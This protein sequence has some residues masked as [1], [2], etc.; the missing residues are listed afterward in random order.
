MFFKLFT[1]PL[2]FFCTIIVFFPSTEASTGVRKGNVVFSA[3]INEDSRKIECSE[4]EVFSSFK[5]CVE[6]LSTRPEG[7]R[8]V[9]LVN[10]LLEIY[11]SFEDSVTF[12]IN[13]S[14]DGKPSFTGWNSG[15]PP[16]KNSGNEEIF[17]KPR[18]SFIEPKTE[19]EQK[20]QQLLSKVLILEES[21][22]END[23]YPLKLIT[24]EEAFD[25]EPNDEI[26]IF[27][28]FLDKAKFANDEKFKHFFDVIVREEEP[29]R[30]TPTLALAFLR[31]V[32]PEEGPQGNP[33]FV[34]LAH[35]LIHMK[36]FLEEQIFLHQVASRLAQLCVS[37]SPEVIGAVKA[38]C[39]IENDLPAS[40]KEI[41]Q[42]ILSSVKSFEQFRKLSELVSRLATKHKIDTTCPMQFTG[43]IDDLK[44][45]PYSASKA[46]NER[47]V[48]DFFAFVKGDYAKK[49]GNGIESFPDLEELRTVFGPDRDGITENIIRKEFNLPERLAYL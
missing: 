20:K 38:L 48:E 15:S 7:K 39:G 24:V 26:W 36:H 8:L 49:F 10:Q 13:E 40:E 29:K 41:Q 23:N 47:E 6:Y 25:L 44:C 45:F 35:E 46:S 30:S 19:E 5:S 32:K 18:L 34:V 2:A 12:Y 33:Y 22:K 11:F 31:G 14:S 9:D 16:I 43:Q 28:A 42:S 17:I 21:K 3:T 4:K 1:V 37:Q 27:D